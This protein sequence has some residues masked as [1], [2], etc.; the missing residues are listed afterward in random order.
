MANLTQ[1]DVTELQNYL[2]NGDRGGFYYAYAQKVGATNNTTFNQVMIQAQITTY[3]GLWGGAA[4]LGN[5]YA[6]ETAGLD[7]NGDVLY[8]IKLDQFSLEIAQRLMDAIYTDVVIK[9]KS[10]IFTA[11]EIQELDYSVWLEKGMGDLFPGN[12]QRGI[13]EDGIPVNSTIYEFLTAAQTQ[14]LR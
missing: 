9:N 8:N 4:Q 5:N 10:G 11:D 1:A 13:V 12:R 3:G 14:E 7:S 2:N 6:Q